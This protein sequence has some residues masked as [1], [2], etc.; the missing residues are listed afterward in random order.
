MEEFLPPN[1]ILEYFNIY[2]RFTAIVDGLPQLDLECK[3]ALRLKWTVYCNLLYYIWLKY[4]VLEDLGAHP[5]SSCGGLGA[6]QAPWGPAGGL[7]PSVRLEY[8]NFEV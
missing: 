7:Q 5:S 8:L 1:M 4:I 3:T 2:W 6:L